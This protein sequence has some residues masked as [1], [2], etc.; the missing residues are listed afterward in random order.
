MAKGFIFCSIVL[1][2]A[3]IIQ[4]SF[5]LE[6]ERKIYKPNNNTLEYLPIKPGRIY[7]ITFNRTKM[8]P[9][10]FT[11]RYGSNPKYNI[12]KP[13]KPLFFNTTIKCSKGTELKCN[14][15]FGRRN[16]ICQTIEPKPF[17][18]CP[19]GTVR[20]CDKNFKCKCKF[21]LDKF[22]KHDTFEKIKLE[23]KVEN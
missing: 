16:C 6:I 15:I 12:P 8:I 7:N 4:S 18:R 19:L 14:Y 23:K 21:T 17:I 11:K 9:L 5:A 13:Q 1:S 22:P 10:N 3:F 2:F 20:S